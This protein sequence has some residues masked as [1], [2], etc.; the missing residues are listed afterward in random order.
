LSGAVTPVPFSNAGGGPTTIGVTGGPP[1]GTLTVP[2]SGNTIYPVRLDVEYV[3]GVLTPVPNWNNPT[4]TGQVNQ[5]D[6]IFGGGGN[7]TIHGSPGAD[8]IEGGDGMHI[9]GAPDPCAAVPPTPTAPAAGCAPTGDNIIFGGEGNSS[10]EGGPGNGD[11]LGGP[12]NK[13]LNVKRVD[14]TIAPKV[15]DAGNCM[16]LAFPTI[17]ADP[18]SLG[19]ANG[20][21]ATNPSFPQYQWAN[22]SYASRFPAPNGKTYD[23]DPAGRDNGGTTSHTPVF[24]QVV[25]SGMNRDLDQAQGFG[26]R[27]IGPN[28]AYNLFYVCPA[29]YGGYQIIRALK[30]AL[31]SFEQQ[32]ASLDGAYNVNT[33]AKEPS[34]FGSGDYEIALVYSGSGNNGSAYP[35][36]AGHFTC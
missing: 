28:G 2:G 17:N 10:V 6:V 33:T 9:Q 11:I 31:L 30:P 1:Y 20:Y 32:L 3:D 26:D 27:M 29:A 14:T 13:D 19:A 25:I 35:T 22:Q 24:G 21:C 23:Y 15:D 16:P 8:F 5:H 4:A 12:G 18:S 36:T 34:S 7:N